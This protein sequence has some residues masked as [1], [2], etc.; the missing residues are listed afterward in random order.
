MGSLN[1]LVQ[2]PIYVDANTL[3]YTVERV[4]P[5]FQLLDPLWQTLAIQQARAI[6][7][8]LTKII[9]K[10]AGL[11]PMRMKGFAWLQPAQAESL[12]RLS[13]VWQCAILLL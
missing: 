2:S 6:I 10:A 9:R 3:I 12:L 8:E 13:H 7:S 11:Q 5:Y 1:A 4:S